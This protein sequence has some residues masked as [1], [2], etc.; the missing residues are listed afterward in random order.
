MATEGNGKNSARGRHACREPQAWRPR[1]AVRQ[2]IPQIHVLAGEQYRPLRNPP[3]YGDVFVVN[4]SY[5]IRAWV[6]LFIG[7]YHCTSYNFIQRFSAPPF[8]FAFFYVRIICLCI[9]RKAVCIHK[10]A[11]F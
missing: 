1:F 2:T 7:S 6:S 3:A 8:S 5:H 9:A 4:P 10:F 11:V